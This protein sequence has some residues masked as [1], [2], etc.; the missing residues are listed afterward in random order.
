[1]HGTPIFLFFGTRMT[2]QQQVVFNLFPRLLCRRRRHPAWRL[3]LARVGLGGRRPLRSL[4]LEDHRIHR[5]AQLLGQP[6]VL[7]HGSLQTLATE[8]C[9]TERRTYYQENLKPGKETLFSTAFFM[10]FDT[11]F[12]DWKGNS[13]FPPPLCSLKSAF[14]KKY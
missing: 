9:Q 11:E 12:S 5:P 3:L 2:R 8:A 10:T 14:N 7:Q 13:F 1:M 4:V 6:P